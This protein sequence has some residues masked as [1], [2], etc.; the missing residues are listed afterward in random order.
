MAVSLHEQEEA[1]KL[2]PGLLEEEEELQFTQFTNDD[3][4]ILGSDLVANAKKEYPGQGIAILI[5]R[6]AQVLFQYAMKGTTVDS[7]NWLRR[8]NN[9]VV[10]LQHSSYY[11]GRSLASKGQKEMEQSYR[12]SMTDYACHGGGFPLLIKNVGCVGAIVVSGLKQDQDH[13]LVVKSIRELIQRHSS[14]S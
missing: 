9:T 11:I 10:R 12:V 5:T 13:T 8:K 2:L 1:G 14:A 3:A 6:N 4:L 7:E